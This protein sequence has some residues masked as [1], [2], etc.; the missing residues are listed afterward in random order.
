[1]KLTNPTDDELNAIFEEH[2][3]GN[4]RAYVDI[5]ND[6]PRTN[7]VKSADAVLSYLEGSTGVMSE[8][9]IGWDRGGNSCG[10][11]DKHPTVWRVWVA[12]S[13][14]DVGAEWWTYSGFNGEAS[15]FPRAA[16]IALLRAK[17]IEIAFSL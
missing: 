17:G 11:H 16:V 2:V 3:C 8:H 13:D 7:Y 5:L 10:H 1:M 6:E 12:E 4:D 15:T 14:E 9:M